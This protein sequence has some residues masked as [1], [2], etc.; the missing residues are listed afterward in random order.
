[1]SEDD[2]PV[3]GFFCFFKGFF[4]PEECESLLEKKCYS[5]SRFPLTAQRA[6]EHGFVGRMPSYSRLGWIPRSGKRYEGTWDWCDQEKINWPFS[7][8]RKLLLAV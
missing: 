3:A 8:S 5:E 2:V 6:S 1:M 4:E 7:R